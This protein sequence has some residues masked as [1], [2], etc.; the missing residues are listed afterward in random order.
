MAGVVKVR[1]CEEIQRL[2]SFCKL[3]YR[4]VSSVDAPEVQGDTKLD[5]ME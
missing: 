1:A 5:Y 4:N 2:V 3:I